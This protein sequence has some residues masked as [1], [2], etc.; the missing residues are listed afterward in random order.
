VRALS[1]AA[2]ATYLYHLFITIPLAE[3]LVAPPGEP[4]LAAILLPW[5]CGLAGS[6]LLVS[7]VR[8]L[9]GDR[10]RDLIGA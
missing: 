9:F 10:S 1:D 5:S 6:L 4:R 2:Y 7:I 8:R 3:A